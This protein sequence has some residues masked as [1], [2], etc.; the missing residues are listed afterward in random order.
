[1]E[2]K[3]QFLNDRQLPFAKVLGLKFL[4]ATETGVKAEMV[5][6]VLDMAR[7]PEFAGYRIARYEILPPEGEGEAR[8][9]LDVGDPADPVGPEET[10]HQV[11]PAGRSL[12]GAVTVTSTVPGAIET[13]VSATNSLAR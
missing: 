8:L 2:D 10:W 13:T 4:A 5:A 1:M 12:V 3:T 7:G 11:A 6:T 9:E